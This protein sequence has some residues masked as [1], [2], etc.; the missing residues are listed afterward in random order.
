M[1]SAQVVKTH[2]GRFET[3][4]PAATG[5]DKQHETKASSPKCIR[6]AQLTHYPSLEMG[7]LGISVSP[8]SYWL[9]EWGLLLMVMAN[10]ER[11]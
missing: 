3:V 8:P 7:R 4:L 10:H 6:S 9:A 5:P 11:G 1:G 2:M